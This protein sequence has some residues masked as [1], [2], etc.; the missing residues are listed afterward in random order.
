[1]VEGDSGN[2]V[3]GI[4]IYANT[5]EGCGGIA[6]DGDFGPATLKAVKC[7]QIRLDVTSDG[8]VGPITWGTMQSDLGKTTTSGGWVYYGANPGTKEFR[9]NTST[10][11]WDALDPF[12]GTWVAM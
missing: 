9:E 3:I 4:Q 5:I 10:D 8:S 1:M 2:L 6:D 7:M 11:V 12:N